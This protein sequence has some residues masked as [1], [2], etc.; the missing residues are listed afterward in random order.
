MQKHRLSLHAQHSEVRY[1]LNRAYIGCRGLL[2]KSA[3]AGSWGWVL[4]VIR[5]SSS[6]PMIE[7]LAPHFSTASVC[8]GGLEGP[9]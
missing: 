5:H 6:F 3:R 2:S 4:I 1:G 9:G 8:Q 7:V